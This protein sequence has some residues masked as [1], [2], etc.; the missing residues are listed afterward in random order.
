MTAAAREGGAARRRS[1][2][3]R[4]IRRL[5]RR[6]LERPRE[7]A[8]HPESLYPLVELIW[9]KPRDGG[10]NFGD[11]LSEVIVTKILANHGLSLKDQTDRRARLLA[12]GSVLHFAK[13]DDVIW[14]S[15]VNGKMPEAKHVFGTLDVRAV[16]GPLTGEF[17]R[18][19]RIEV[20]PIYGDPAL[21]LPHLFPHLRPRPTRPL[22]VVPNL[23]DVARLS[24]NGVDHLSPRLGWNTCVEEILRAELVVASSLHG[25]IVAEAFGIPARYVRFS[26]NENLFKYEDYVLG[27][28]RDKLEPADSIGEA[29]EMGGMPPIRFDGRRLLDAFPFD[30]WR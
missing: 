11:V 18:K 16:R 22:V 7:E 10:L 30:L 15:G 3:E 6:W 2:V 4:A 28:G 19:R 26:E 8:S 27:T 21:L 25:I 5:E 9:W 1:L 13:D 14:G 20:P 17:L 12:V 24:A 29:R 23:H